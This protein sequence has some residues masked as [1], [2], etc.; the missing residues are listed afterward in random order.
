MTTIRQYIVRLPGVFI[1]IYGNNGVYK[2]KLIDID[3]QD[4]V[5]ETDYVYD[6]HGV[7]YDDA[8]KISKEYLYNVQPTIREQ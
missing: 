1:F 6:N 7:A 3:T 2:I 8:Y 5:Y 4:I